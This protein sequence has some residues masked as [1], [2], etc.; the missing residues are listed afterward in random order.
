MNVKKFLLCAPLMLIL[1]ACE[2]DCQRVRTQNQQLYKETFL[3]CLDKTAEARKGQTY[4]T[5]DDEDYDEV[6]EACDR[7]AWE[8]VCKTK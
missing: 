2:P 8:T 4:S 5:N 6:V 1:T 3:A 7:S